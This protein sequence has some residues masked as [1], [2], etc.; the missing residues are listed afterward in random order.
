MDLLNP[1][2][3]NLQVRE[4]LKIGV[5]IEGISEEITTCSEDAIGLL[6]KGAINRHVG[7]TNMNQ[8]SSRSHSVFSMIIE[9]KTVLEGI[10]NV[11][12]SKFNFVD[13]AGSERQKQTAATGARLK[14]ATNIN[15]SLTVLGSVINA[16]VDIATGKP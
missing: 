11:K 8:E 15:K 4:D 10:T 16:L 7:A 12:T 14:E 9:S 13:L 5:Y 3:G 2:A 1:T 6:Q